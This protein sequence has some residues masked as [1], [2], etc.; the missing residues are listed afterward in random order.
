MSV[1]RFII[2]PILI[3]TT[4]YTYC[5]YNLN[6]LLAKQHQINCS[7]ACLLCNNTKAFNENL[8]MYL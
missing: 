7:F 3:C 1:N 4:I 8:F 5:I 6:E 2:S